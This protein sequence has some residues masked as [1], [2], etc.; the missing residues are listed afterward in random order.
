VTFRFDM[1]G[2][3]NGRNGF[4]L[5]VLKEDDLK[6]STQEFDLC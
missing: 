6:F 4:E 5:K 3:F 2:V 1:F